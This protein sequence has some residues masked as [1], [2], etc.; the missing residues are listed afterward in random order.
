MNV[1]PSH[2]IIEYEAAN[3]MPLNARDAIR[4]SPS[5]RKV[6]EIM[7]TQ[8]SVRERRLRDSVKESADAGV[9]VLI[10]LCRITITVIG[11]YVNECMG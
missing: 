5:P 4:G 6:L 2:L 1:G 11:K 9:E 3:A 7:P 10:G 8:A